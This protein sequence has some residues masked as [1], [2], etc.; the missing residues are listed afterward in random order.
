MIFVFI[1]KLDVDRLD[2]IS[3]TKPLMCNKKNCVPRVRFLLKKCVCLLHI[4]VTMTD[5]WRPLADIFREAKSDSFR[6]LTEKDCFCCM[7]FSCFFAKAYYS[8]M[9]FLETRII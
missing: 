9:L 3:W 2:F 1:F 8:A 4:D 5:L 7:S 6:T